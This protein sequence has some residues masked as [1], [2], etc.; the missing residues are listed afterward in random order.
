MEYCA[1]GSLSAGL[2]QRQ[3]PLDL[4]VALRVAQQAPTVSASRTSRV[5]STVTS[6]PRTS[7]SRTRR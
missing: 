4:D 3:K 6:S 2:L 7:S 5:S 1:G